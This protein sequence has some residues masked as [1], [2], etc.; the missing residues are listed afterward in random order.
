MANAWISLF[1]D[2]WSQK[3]S[4]HFLWS[5]AQVLKLYFQSLSSKALL[6]FGTHAAQIWGTLTPFDAT[7]KCYYSC[8]LIKQDCLA[9]G[10]IS[11]VGCF[12]N[13]HTNESFEFL[14]T[15]PTREDGTVGPSWDGRCPSGHISTL[16]KAHWP[17]LTVTLYYVYQCRL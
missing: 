9:N 3:H 13:S 14:C 8:T 16:E 4:V 11:S 5:S 12:L 10:K 6:F 17:V 2:T 15:L 7:A 1:G